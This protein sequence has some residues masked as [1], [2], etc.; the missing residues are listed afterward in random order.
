M[1]CYCSD[2][3]DLLC[4]DRRKVWTVKGMERKNIIRII[5]CDASIQFLWNGG[6]QWKLDYLVAQQ[7]MRSLSKIMKRALLWVE[8]YY[9]AAFCFTFRG[10]LWLSWAILDYWSHIIHMLVLTSNNHRAVMSFVEH[11]VPLIGEVGIIIIC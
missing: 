10:I 1:S 4:S 9:I 11:R 7:F 5:L 3:A 8:E 2:Y 6:E